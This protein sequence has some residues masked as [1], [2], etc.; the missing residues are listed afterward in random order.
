MITFT[1]SAER[2]FWERMFCDLARGSAKV[3]VQTR[4]GDLRGILD[5]IAEMSD[6]AVMV[7]RERL[8]PPKEK[9]R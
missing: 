7:R 9:E 3:L 6:L 4:P 8:A 1:A 2:A 5:A